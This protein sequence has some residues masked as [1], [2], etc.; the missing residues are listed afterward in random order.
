VI[1]NPRIVEGQ[2]HGSLAHG[3]GEAL[4]ERMV[5]D[6]DG[7]VLTGSLLDYPVPMAPVL[8]N[9]TTGHIETPSPLQPLG[10]KGAGEAGNIGA[11]P[12]IVSAV[13]DALSPLGVTT[14]DV[15]LHPERIWRLIHDAELRQA[16]GPRDAG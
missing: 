12:T 2:I 14:V 8:P 6:A 13:L 4:F 9:W 5:Y 11:P 7:Q 10:A 15:P 1:V 16:R 3:L